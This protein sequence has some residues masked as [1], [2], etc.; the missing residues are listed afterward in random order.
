MTPGDIIRLNRLYKCSE[1]SIQ[2]LQRLMMEDREEQSDNSDN[3]KLSDKENPSDNNVQFNKAIEL[4]QQDSTIEDLVEKVGDMMLKES[5]DDCAHAKDTANTNDLIDDPFIGWPDGI[6]YYQYDEPVTME[7]RQKVTAA[8]KDIT[9]VSCIQFKVGQSKQ[10]DVVRISSSS[11]EMFC[12]PYIGWLAYGDNMLLLNDKST[13]GDIIHN[14]LHTLGFP[15]MHIVNERDNHIK[16]QRDNIIEAKTYYFRKAVTPINMFNTNYDTG[17]IMHFPSTAFAKNTSIPTIIPLDPLN[18][19]NMG[20]KESKSIKMSIK[21]Q[22]KLL[23]QILSF[24]EMSEGDILRLNR[25]YKCE[26]KPIPATSKELKTKEKDFDIYD[27]KLNEAK[28]SKEEDNSAEDYSEKDTRI[29]DMLLDENQLEYLYAKEGT[30]RHGLTN[31]FFNHWPEAVVYYQYNKSVTSKYREVVASAMKYIEDVS[32][33]KFKVRSEN[34]THKNYVQIRAKTGCS[35]SVGMRRVGA[36]SLNL[37]IKR[38]TEGNVIHELLHTLGFLHMHTANERDNHIKIQW[39]NVIETAK[40]NFELIHASVSM[41]NTSYD[42]DSIMHYPPKAFAKNKT[43]HTIIP[44]DKLSAKNMGQRK[45]KSIE[46]SRNNL[47]NRGSLQ[48]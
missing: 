38:C 17:S 19:K 24:L 46:I 36:Q 40:R 21:N 12:S 2:E 34:A 1:E 32:C 33:I 28:G 25:K 6:V 9:D 35:S 4:D 16:I 11:D 42:F 13:K 7:L 47:T 37:D 48:K 3:S 43:I 30:R 18:A 23:N 44:M 31:K 15:H 39:D 41:F 45:G 10:G 8:M 5:Q 22:T 26:T 20:Q 29:G 27:E 14:L